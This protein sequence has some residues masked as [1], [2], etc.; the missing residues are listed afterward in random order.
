LHQTAAA[1]HLPFEDRE[2]AG[3]VKWMIRF[4]AIAPIR[5]DK[6]CVG[7]FEGRGII[8]PAFEMSFNPDLAAEVRRSLEEV[9]EQDDIL[10]VFVRLFGMAGDR[11]G[12]QDDLPGLVGGP[13]RIR[14][15]N[16]PAQAKQEE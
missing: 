9:F 16:Q 6:D 8:G 1:F 3:N 13:C 15:D 2:P 10:F 7:I 4:A 5:G 12:E 14:P 11:S